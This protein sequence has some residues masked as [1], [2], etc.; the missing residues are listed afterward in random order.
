[1]KFVQLGFVL[2][3]WIVLPSAGSSQTVPKKSPPLIVVS[4]RP[5]ALLVQDICQD[6]CKALAMVP[7][8][9][10]EHHWEASPKQMITFKDAVAGVGVGLDFDERFFNR[11]LPK[12]AKN[13]QKILYFGS[14]LDPIT[15]NDQASSKEVDKSKK[16]NSHSHDGHHDHEDDHAHVHGAFDPHVWFDPQRIQ[17]AVPLIVEFLAKEL[18]EPSSAKIRTQGEI[19]LKSLRTLD[20]TVED[21]LKKAPKRPVVVFHDALN[22][23]GKRY[24]QTTESLVHGGSGHEVS[25]K[26]FGGLTKKLKGSSVA[27]IV[28]EREDGAAK[29]LAKTL[30]TK[31]VVLDFSAKGEWKTYD[32][33]LLGFARDWNALLL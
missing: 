4:V 14:S 21:I 20:Q 6:E 30:K 3:S 23:W 18:G 8:G 5:L 22:Y 13:K 17:V 27:A 7:P 33:W 1:M 9:V 19:V 31:V 2:F 24:S 12:L 28:V 25:A 11:V 15:W 29:N 10:S 16:V 26:T 32:S